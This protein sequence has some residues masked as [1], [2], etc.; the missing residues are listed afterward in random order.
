MKKNNPFLSIFSVNKPVIGV[1]HLLPLEGEPGFSGLKP[2]LQSAKQDIDA[3]QQGGIDGII[4][5]NWHSDS[6][7]PF[8]Y[9]KTVVSFS[10]VVHQLKPCITVPFGINVLHNDYKTALDL[11]MEHTAD[12]VQCDVFVDS[13]KSNFSFSQTAAQDP[14]IINMP[15][16][17][18]KSYAVRIGAS[19]IPLVVF[20]QPKHYL[21]LE[22][23]KSIKTSAT[24]AKLS[25]AS[26]IVITQETGIAPTLSKIR[27]A[28]SAVDELPVGIG[29]GLS[30]KNTEEYVPLVDFVIVG[31]ALKKEGKIE[32]P[33]A[34]NR[35]KKL[36]QQVNKIRSS[37]Y[38]QQSNE[39]F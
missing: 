13:V 3:L 32:N 35:V 4:M 28:K 33:V 36:I 15:A 11:T 23:Y 26:A 24:Q 38:T 18:I 39:D 37:M 16:K 10:E 34:L 17:N 7:G 5:E 1:L 2:V 29:S 31:T 9:Q 12:F 30:A 8:V 19:H 14:F 20:I 25:G 21:L 6:P 22:K 27:E